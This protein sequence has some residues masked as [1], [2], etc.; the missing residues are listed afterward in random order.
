M[1]LEIDK[2]NLKIVMISDSE[3]PSLGQN[4]KGL[5]LRQWEKRTEYFDA[6]YGREKEKM[7]LL[8]AFERSYEKSQLVF[9]KGSAGIGKT[10]FAHSIK[11][12]CEQKNCLFISGKFDPQASQTPYSGLIMSLGDLFH[13]L[14]DLEE[15]EK[16]VIRIQL[17]ELLKGSIPFL[18]EN[19]PYLRDFLG[20][21]PIISLI[22]DEENNPLQFLNVFEKCFSFFA[23]EKT[24]LILFLDDLQWAD[25]A[26]LDF[27]QNLALDKTSRY[28]IIL[29]YRKPEVKY[30]HPATNNFEFLNQ[31]GIEKTEIELFPFSLDQ[32][33]KW[34]ETSLRLPKDQIGAISSFIHN[35]SE[36]NPY[37]I[38]LLLI[39]FLN[40]GAHESSWNKDLALA[41]V[42]EKVPYDSTFSWLVSLLQN[43]DPLIKEVLKLGACLGGSFDV[44]LL[45]SITHNS[46]ISIRNALK[47]AYE[48]GLIDESLSKNDYK[49]SHEKVE[50]AALSLLDERTKKEVNHALGKQMLKSYSEAD[51]QKN[52]FTVVYQYNQAGSVIEKP[53]EQMQVATLNLYA[54]RKAVQSG[55]YSMAQNYL[56]YGLSFLPP[57][58]WKSHYKLTYELMLLSGESIYLMGDFERAKK[59]LNQLLNLS[60]NNEDKLEVLTLMIKLFTSTADYAG[61]VKSGQ[62]ALALLDIK[63]PTR[64][65]KF[66][67]FKE[68]IATHYHTMGKPLET[69]SSLKPMKDEKV[70]AEIRI[71]ALL[72]PSAYLKY[73]DLLAFYVM[74]ALQLT[75]K[76]G[77]N[78][79]APNL[80]TSWAIFNNKLY[81]NIEMIDSIGK[82]SIQMAYKPENRKSL[83]AV[84]FLYGTFIAPFRLPM[85]DSLEHLEKSYQTGVS[86]GDIIYAIFSLIQTGIVEYV[87][88]NSLDLTQSK[89]SKKIELIENYKEA[90][91]AQA[92]KGLLQACKALKGETRYPTSLDDHSFNEKDF[93]N[94]LKEQELT[95]SQFIV[96]T[97]KIQ[98]AVLFNKSEEAFS[99]VSKVEAV[100]PYTKEELVY[101]DFIFYSS[102]A[103]VKLYPSKES[104]TKK[105]FKKKLDKNLKFLKKIEK[106]APYNFGAKSNLLE[107]EIHFLFGRKLEAIRAYEASLKFS[108]A[109]HQ[110]QIQALG[111]EYFA[112]FWT[113]EGINEAATQFLEL[114]F[115]KYAEWGAT[116]K[117]NELMKKLIILKN[118]KDIKPKK[119]I[120]WS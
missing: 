53:D 63:V 38:K 10:T 64:G 102:L 42:K 14:L 4:S 54:A 48:Q 19:I 94:Y 95:T 56:E 58:P 26:S 109:N 50:L 103:M 97:A 12:L 74:K 117:A 5:S 86:Q 57:D 55:A 98:I 45:S 9:I 116:A 99:L 44:D 113:A 81:R 27:I 100:M 106:E 111:H 23:T 24:P 112:D 52:I 77:M 118:G 51:L 85:K 47:C 108:K 11:N 89:L 39:S 20:H 66:H 13:Q 115:Q 104:N 79:L 67:L 29:S 110:L 21:A 75:L 31:E 80:F 71:L 61:A 33:S 82:L 7:Q 88:G 41:K 84:L 60:N 107:A 120:K 35:K 16:E 8:H 90:S 72:L 105:E 32:V 30:D 6:L 18:S 59:S 87:S 70:L 65:I 68:F 119:E 62:Q 3:D 93:F 49:F 46:K 92:L 114:S 76:Y 2:V 28:L 78:R 69:F 25:N 15:G 37:F 36:G 101:I 96:L 73:R 1:T 17:L 91:R 83:P 40:E 43:G 22:K 34:T